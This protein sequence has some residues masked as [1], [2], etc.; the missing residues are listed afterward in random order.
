M[1]KSTSLGSRPALRA[2]SS[3]RLRVFSNVSKL[4]PAPSSSPSATSP[5]MRMVRGPAAATYTGTWRGAMR[6]RLCVPS[7]TSQSPASRRRS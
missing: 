7:K 5:A 2:P 6:M 4:R 3:S 1:Q